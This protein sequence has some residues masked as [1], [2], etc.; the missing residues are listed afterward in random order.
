[1]TDVEIENKT[2]L[3]GIKCTGHSGYAEAG[4]DIVC[5]GISTLT[6][7]FVMAVETYSDTEDIEIKINEYEDGYMHILYYDPEGIL[8][9][10]FEMAK[11]GLEAISDAYPNNVNITY[12]L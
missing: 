10:A 12:N 3:Y 7:S 5:A 11:L 6:Q 9:P 8:K 2:N 1:M 4:K